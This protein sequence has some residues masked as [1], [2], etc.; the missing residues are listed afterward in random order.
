MVIFNSER[1]RDRGAENPRLCVAWWR[2][3]GRKKCS[4]RCSLQK[5][6]FQFWNGGDR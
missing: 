2:E 5:N 3:Y 6:S 4:D 1:S